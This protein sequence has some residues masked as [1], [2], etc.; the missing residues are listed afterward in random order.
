MRFGFILPTSEP[1]VCAELAALA[2]HSGWDGVFI[3]DSIAIET[4]TVP[5]QPAYDPWVTL[6]AMAVAT[7]RVRLGTMLTALPRRR[8]WKLA[9]EVMTLDHLSLGRAMLATGMGAAP[10]DAGFYKV[11]EPMDL[12]TRAELLDEGLALLDGLWR[13]QPVTFHGKHYQVEGLT[14]LPRPVQ[15]PRVPLWVVGVWPRPKSL[16]RALRYDGMIPQMQSVAGQAPG[17]VTP[18]DLRAMRAYIAQHRPGPEPFDLIAEGELPAGD[19]ARAAAQAQPY[20]EAGATWFL[21]SRWAAGEEW[22]R[23]VRARLAEAPPRMKDE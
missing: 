13:G 11:G 8:P 16:A 1:R 20:A 9:R 5:P 2:E 18:D 23:V 15:Q 19:A 21:E 3:P 10:D 7:R 14:L 12:K 17:P 4:P 6:A 22:E